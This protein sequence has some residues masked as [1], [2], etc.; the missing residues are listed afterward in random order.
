VDDSGCYVPFEDTEPASLLCEIEQIFSVSQ[1]GS[2]T[3][4][5]SVTALGTFIGRHGRALNTIVSK[6]AH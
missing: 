4:L 5:G 1:Q 2:V 3:G 6:G